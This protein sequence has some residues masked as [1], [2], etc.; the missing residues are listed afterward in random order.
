LEYIIFIL[1]FKALKTK[2]LIEPFHISQKKE[3]HREEPG[4]LA[5]VFVYRTFSPVEKRESSTNTRMYLHI[6]KENFDKNKNP[7]GDLF[8]NSG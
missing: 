6:S 5:G 4:A 3:Y 7:L 1:T 2:S 8:F